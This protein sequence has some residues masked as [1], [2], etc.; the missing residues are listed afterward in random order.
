MLFGGIYYTES[1][2]ALTK[3]RSDSSRILTIFF[4]FLVDDQYWAVS[5][6][7][8]QSGFPRPIH[9]LGFPMS[10]RKI[11]AAVHDQSTRRTYF[12]VGNKYWR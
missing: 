9:N 1:S 2:G 11:D 12:F 5:G 7:Q 3:R 6:Y 8:I 4:C 10:V